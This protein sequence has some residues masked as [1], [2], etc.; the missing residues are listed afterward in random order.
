MLVNGAIWEIET[1]PALT[2]PELVCAYDLGLLIEI[3]GRIGEALVE[4]YRSGEFVRE[5]KFSF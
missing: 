3:G 1:L 5:D 2:L 4:E